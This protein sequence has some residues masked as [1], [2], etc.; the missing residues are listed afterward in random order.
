MNKKKGVDVTQDHP[1]QT[2]RIET[3][4]QTEIPLRVIELKD[5]RSS[6]GGQVSGMVGCGIL[7]TSRRDCHAPRA[8]RLGMISG[9]REQALRPGHRAVGLLQ[10]DGMLHRPS[11]GGG[12]WRVVA[13][14]VRDLHR[15]A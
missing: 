8:H 12:G 9:G 11:R 1:S 15:Q 3:V 7:S 5:L 2:I 10:V 13:P 14:F 6:P 4:G